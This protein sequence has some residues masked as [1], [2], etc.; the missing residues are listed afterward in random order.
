VKT[1]FDASHAEACSEFGVDASD[2]A[3]RVTYRMYMKVFAS[4]LESLAVW[5]SDTWNR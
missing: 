4:V 1:C 5:D 3:K 2:E